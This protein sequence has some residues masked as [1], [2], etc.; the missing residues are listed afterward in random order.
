VLRYA[1]AILLVALAAFLQQA[2]TYKEVRTLA[3]STLLY[4][5]ILLSAWLSFDTFF[6]RFHQ[7]F[8][9]GDSWLFYYSDSLIQF[10]PLP[11]WMDATLIL[12]ALS[13][14]EGL[15]LGAAS[16]VYLKRSEGRA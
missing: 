13:L 16:L 2:L 5:A 14:L 10:Y 11:F 1:A 7:V 3:P 4:G 12:G 6:T 8:F 15:V 9:S